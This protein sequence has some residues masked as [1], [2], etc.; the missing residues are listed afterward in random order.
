MERKFFCLIEQKKNI[1]K[2]ILNHK[3]TL[4]LNQKN[5]LGLENVCIINATPKNDYKKLLMLL[6]FN[7]IK[8]ICDCIIDRRS[9]LRD[10]SKKYFIRYSDGSFFYINQRNFQR[11][12][13][14]NEKL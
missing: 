2:I 14:L 10:I 5:S 9:K 12:I 4:E 6:D 3:N 13:Y 11:K 7:Q 1:K 8:Y